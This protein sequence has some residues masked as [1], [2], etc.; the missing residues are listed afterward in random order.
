MKN[1]TI[2]GAI[3]IIIAVI[4]AF[5][6]SPRLSSAAAND[7]TSVVVLSNS[8]TQ[9]SQID[10]DDI[11][12]VSINSSAVPS[13][14]VTDASTVVGM[15]AKTD[16]YSGD[17][18]TSAKLVTDEG[19]VTANDVLANLDGDKVAISFKVDSYSAS[20]S[21]KLQNGDI[22]SIIATD[23]DDFGSSYILIP[24]ALTYVQV[25]TT[26]TS[27]GIDKDNV[28]VEEDGS[29]DSPSTITVLVTPYQAMLITMYQQNGSLSTAL[30]YRGDSDTADSYIAL[31]DEYL[32]AL[33]EIED[34]DIVVTDTADTE[35]S[36]FADLTGDDYLEVLEVL[37]SM[38]DE[39]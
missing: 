14:A 1:R 16:L 24:E 37:E 32:E 22:I 39:E 36:S 27:S 9:G 2:T 30:V 12:Y 4:L 17:F 3:C 20:L 19:L 8:V 5:V 33:A 28:V 34:T 21:G 29:F 6:V 11:T 23:Y 26:T 18:L 31:Q 15:Y 13:G 35:Y 7:T 10:E 38:E 25:I